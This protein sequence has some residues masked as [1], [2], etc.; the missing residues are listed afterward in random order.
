M[1]V[2]TRF[3]V[4]YVPAEVSWVSI[5]Q[6][7]DY[8]DLD[9]VTREREASGEEWGVLAAD[10]KWCL[11]GLPHIALPAS[12][13]RWPGTVSQQGLFVWSELLASEF[14]TVFRGHNLTPKMYHYSWWLYDFV[15]S[16]HCSG[17]SK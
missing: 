6:T 8:L 1:Q 12:Y 10:D 17:V 16:N 15:I 4:I 14:E 2:D 7:N 5:P 13:H 11:E 9:L 3:P